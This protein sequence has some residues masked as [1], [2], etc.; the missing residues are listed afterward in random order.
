[1]QVIWTLTVSATPFNQ[2]TID[3]FRAKNGRGVGRWGDDLLL[4]TSKGATTAHDI[5]TPLVQRRQGND[6]IVV[7][8]KGG[9]PEDPQWVRNIQLD[10]AVEIEVATPDGTKRLKA[11]ARVVPDGPERDRLYGYMTEVWP[12]F[13]E[14]EVKTGRTIPVVILEPVESSLDDRAA[15]AL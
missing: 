9:A 6:Y 15:E 13:A 3:E 8:S 2:K 1:V 4:M 7:A 10:P 5:T 14:Y 11:R 12:S